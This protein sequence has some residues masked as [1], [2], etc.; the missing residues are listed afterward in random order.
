MIV[1]T[2]VNKSWQ[3]GIYREQD[4]LDL[5]KISS[6]MFYFSIPIFKHAYLFYKLQAVIEWFIN[7]L[8][9]KYFVVVRHSDRLNTHSYISVNRYTNN[10]FSIF[11]P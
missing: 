1:F 7:G 6:V 11:A 8:L 5:F 2:V 4:G 3:M 10:G 9:K